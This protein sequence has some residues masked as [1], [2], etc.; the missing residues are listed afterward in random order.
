MG[1]KGVRTRIERGGKRGWDV[2]GEGKGTRR[3]EDGYWENG[4][5]TWE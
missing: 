2:G 1:E 4:G 5:V 3:K